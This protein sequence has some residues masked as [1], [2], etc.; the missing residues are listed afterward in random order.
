[1]TVR[2]AKEAVFHA[3]WGTAKEDLSLSNHLTGHVFM[4]RREIGAAYS[5]R[6]TTGQVVT[7]DGQIAFI[8]CTKLASAA[9]TRLMSGA[10]GQIAR[11]PTFSCIG[12]QRIDLDSK[13]LAALGRDSDTPVHLVTGTFEMLL[14]KLRSDILVM[15]AQMEKDG[16]IY[17]GTTPVFLF[18]EASMGAEYGAELN[19]EVRFDGIYFY[20]Q[21]N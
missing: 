7:M 12:T 3:T 6:N 1:M 21:E 16:R 18:D 20:G 8:K 9:Q 19:E 14:Q 5:A 11:A 15:R 17:F 10:T 2:V 13:L 4:T